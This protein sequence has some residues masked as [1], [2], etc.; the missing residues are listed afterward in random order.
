MKRK[1]RVFRR[2][3]LSMMQKINYR[4]PNV[5]QR[6]NTLKMNR[7]AA[8]LKDEIANLIFLHY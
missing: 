7:L 3:M 1:D 6:C 4:F 5:F 8:S 2:V